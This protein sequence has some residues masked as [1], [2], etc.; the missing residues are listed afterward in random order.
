MR[1]PVVAIVVVGLGS[2]CNYGPYTFTCTDDASCG[3][4]GKC[5]PGGSLC[6]FPDP[7]CP[8]GR[9]YGSLSGDISGQ[10]VMPDA[11]PDASLACYGTAP[12]SICFA[13]PPAGVQTYSGTIDT[14]SSAMCA[15]NV[16][17]GGSNFCV[18]AAGTIMIDAKLRATGAKPLVLLATD[19]ISTTAVIDVS[20]RRGDNPE[21]GAGADPAECATMAGTPPTMGGGGAGGSFVG[22]GGPGAVSANGGS[23]GGAP[24]ARRPATSIALRGGCRGQD[25]EGQNKGAGGHGGGAVLLIAASISLEEDI[26]AGGEGGGGG[27]M[28]TSGGGGGVQAA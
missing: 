19:S 20:S 25:G 4:S 22:P 26:L 18:L 9:S 11:P 24:G 15:T 6:S 16:V 5:E 2:G 17:S 12:I 23:T 14:T 10:C 8:G 27:A 1:T 13:A 3:V 28:N 21:T 7:R